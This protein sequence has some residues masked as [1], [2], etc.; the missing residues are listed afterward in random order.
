MTKPLV[1]LIDDRDYGLSQV[2]N[3]VPAELRDQVQVAHLRTFAAYR[4]AGRPQ[5]EIVLLDYYLDLDGLVGAEVAGEVRTT[6]LVGFSSEPH[7]SQLIIDAAR[8]SFGAAAPRLHAVRKLPDRD[9]NPA[10]A[11][12]FARILAP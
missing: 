8:A 3:A 12:L 4:A 5:A 10:L 9:R 6:H 2:E 7:C 1:L 11:A